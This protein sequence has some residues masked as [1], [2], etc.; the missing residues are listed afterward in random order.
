MTYTRDD[1]NDILLPL[2]G[3]DLTDVW[4][5]TKLPAFGGKTAEEL[6]AE[7]RRELVYGRANMY[8]S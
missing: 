6:W 4:W 5:R 3:D 1:V 8:V 2:L 7:G